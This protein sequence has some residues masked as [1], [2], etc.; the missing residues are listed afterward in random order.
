[1][2][3][4]LVR[5]LLRTTPRPSTASTSTAPSTPP[6]AP[7]PTAPPGRAYP[8]DFSGEAGSP[9][10]TPTGSV[11]AGEVVWAWVPF[12]EDH[13]RGKD[14]PA[15]VI[16]AD[17]PWLLGLPMTSQDHDLDETQERRAGRQWIDVGSGDW[18]RRR[19][20]SEARLDR[21]VRLDPAQVRR[22]GGSVDRAVYDAVL[23]ALEAVRRGEP[24]DD[25]P[26]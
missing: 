9:F 6:S 4:S 18:D 8:G 26:V 15:L 14:R 21:V 12:E 19:R 23:V 16:G 25:D 3:R 2:L 1:M 22:A 5:R 11:G 24:Y 10:A 13:R 17:G 20:R 7:P